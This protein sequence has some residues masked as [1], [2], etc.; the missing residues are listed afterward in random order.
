MPRISQQE[1][2]VV[3][4]APFLEGRY[5][6][7]GGFTVSFE[8]FHADA[9]ATEMF[10]GLPDDRCQ[11]AHWGYVLAGELVH[12]FADR[13]EVYR[14]GDAFYSPPGHVPSV[15]AGTVVIEFSPSAD[16]LRTMEVLDRNMRASAGER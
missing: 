13:T 6:D 3:V 1:A 8:T 14:A 4:D 10:R 16:L 5:Q 2:P 9:D 12:T 15:V 7:L 11:C